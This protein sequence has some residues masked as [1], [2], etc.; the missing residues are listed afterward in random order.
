MKQKKLELLGKVTNYL[1]DHLMV[2][3]EKD[4]DKMLDSS[5]DILNSICENVCGGV[6]HCSDGCPIYYFAVERKEINNKNVN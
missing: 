2:V 5:F 4:I 3:D 6:M 1:T